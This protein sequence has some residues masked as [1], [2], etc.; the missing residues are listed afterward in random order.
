M[1]SSSLIAY[2][3]ESWYDKP[4]GRR[5]DKL[6][7]KLLLK[8][9]E[10]KEEKT[11]LEVG[12]GTGHFTRWFRS[13]G[14]NTVGLDVSREMLSAAKDLSAINLPLIQG[15]AE[16][17]PFKANTFDIVAMITTLEFVTFPIEVI[18]EALRVARKKA[19][20]GMLNIWSPLIL[21]RRIKRIF[22][23]SFYRDAHFYSSKNLKSLI[24]ELAQKKNVSLIRIKD[25]R[26]NSLLSCFTT[27][28]IL[29]IEKAHH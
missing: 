15:K 5:F 10:G 28:F 17:L 7:K 12:C 26:R 2:R 21:Y 24:Y 4:W 8:S 29:E 9:L 6:E 25:I 18:S 1:Y 23:K 14:L 11:L 16:L 22:K 19:V 20:I 27:F 3:Y 13:I